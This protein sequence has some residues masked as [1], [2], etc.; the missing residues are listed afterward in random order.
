M[1]GD[2]CRRWGIG[3][4]D[5]VFLP[6]LLVLLLDGD[7]GV[8]FLGLLN[9]QWMPQSHDAIHEKRRSVQHTPLSSFVLEIWRP[10][11]AFGAASVEAMIVGYP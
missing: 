4:E 6:L 5:A 10:S 7:Q 2:F 11:M 8:T 1:Q 9:R 3:L